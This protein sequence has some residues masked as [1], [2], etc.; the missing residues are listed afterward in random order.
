M[1]QRNRV[2]DTRFTELKKEFWTFS[3]AW[4]LQVLWVF[5]LEL[6]ATRRSC[7]CKQFASKTE[8]HPGE[9]HGTSAVGL[10]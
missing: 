6:P 2:E 10:L 1:R 5:L 9:Q 8:G 4:S 3:I 7:V